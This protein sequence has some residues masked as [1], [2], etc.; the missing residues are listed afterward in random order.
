[1]AKDAVAQGAKCLGGH[2]WLSQSVKN[3]REL[4]DR[5]VSQSVCLSSPMTEIT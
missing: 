5:S 3:E 4:C 2:F 1:M